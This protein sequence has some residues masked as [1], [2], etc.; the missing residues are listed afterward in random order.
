MVDS[1][2]FLHCEF[3]HNPMTLLPPLNYL[4]SYKITPLCVCL[5]FWC[6]F[7]YSQYTVQEEMQSL[8]SVMIP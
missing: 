6:I 4:L 5:A 7:N 2:F 3:P 1:G 8:Q